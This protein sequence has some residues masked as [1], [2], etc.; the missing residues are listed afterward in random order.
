MSTR[1]AGGVAMNRILYVEDDA[2][3]RDDVIAILARA[4]FKIV[5]ASNGREALELCL[6]SP[7]D[8]VITDLVMPEMDGIELIRSLRKIMPELPV[9]AV[10][11]GLSTAASSARPILNAAKALGAAAVLP[12]PFRPH[13]LCRA[14]ERALTHAGAT[15]PGRPTPDPL[16]A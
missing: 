14:V 12:K 15:P 10:S 9:I 16:P 11:G 8:L 4:G 7:P 13:D 6:H 5:G 1:I 3:L 2:D